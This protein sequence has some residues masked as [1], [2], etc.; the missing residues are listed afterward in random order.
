MRRFSVWEGPPADAEVYKSIK[1]KREG[2]VLSFWRGK[3][4]KP[5]SRFVYPNEERI[6]RAITAEK[7]SAD[8]DEESKASRKNDKAERR[9]KMK[10]EIV[11]GTLL[12]N[13]WGY[14]QTQCD[15]YQVVEK[16]GA[17][18]M[19][20]PIGGA[21]VEGSEG[22]DCCYYRAVPDSFTGPA[23]RKVIGPNGISMEHGSCSVT[24]PE[25]KHYCS[26]YA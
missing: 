24:T 3:Q 22:R 18:V 11:V 1:W 13:S 8:E 5:Y 4:A 23:V 19:I 20:R 14:D 7:K 6:E 17:S 21:V 15:F 10:A 16:N 12:H 26:W 25:E 9:A 2:M